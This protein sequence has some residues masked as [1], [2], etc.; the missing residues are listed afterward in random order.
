MPDVQDVAKHREQRGTCS[1]KSLKTGASGRA[2][3]AKRT[4]CSSRSPFTVASVLPAAWLLPNDC[5]CTISNLS[6]RVG[7]ITCCNRLLVASLRPCSSA[8]MYQ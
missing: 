7:N 8:S 4:L 2:G 5:N 1:E 3:Y 6:M